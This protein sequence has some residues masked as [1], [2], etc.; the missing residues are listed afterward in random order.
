MDPLKAQSDLY[1]HYMP[2]IFTIAESTRKLP[3]IYANA[4]TFTQT[5]H[6]NIMLKTAPPAKTNPP[7]SFKPNL[8]TTLNGTIVI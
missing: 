1:F 5:S 8:S 4:D 3:A 7:I 6:P 2:R